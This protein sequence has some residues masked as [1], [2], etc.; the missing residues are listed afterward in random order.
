MPFRAL[1]DLMV[2]NRAYNAHTTGA[3]T[4]WAGVPAVFIEGRHLAGR[5]GA[6]FADA[7]GGGA[8]IVAPSMKGYEDSTH[9]LGTAPVRLQRLRRNLLATH[10]DAPFF[11]LQRL[12]RGQHRVAGLMWG[13]YAAGLLPMHVI[14]AR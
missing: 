7:I 1:A 2:D 12:A 14:A 6:A 5:A 3:D 11:D 10:D 8:S 4:L 9:A 13:V